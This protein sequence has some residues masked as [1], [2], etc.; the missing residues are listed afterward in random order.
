MDQWLEFAKGPLFAITFL[1]ML[2]GLTR[3][4]VVQV[5]LLAT[6][7]RTLRRVA[8]RR[9]L[10]DSLSWVLPFQHLTRGT[11]ILTFTSILFHAGAILVPLFLAD[12]VVLWES[13]LGISLPRLSA[14]AADTLTL[15]TIALVLVLLS[16]RV[17]T[18]RSR[19]LSKTGDY[20]ILAVVLLPFVT[21][22]LAAHPGI[23]PLPWQTMML[24]HV[25]SAEALFLTIPFTK[26]AHIVLFPFDRLSQVHWQLRAGAGEKVA[27]ALYGEEAKV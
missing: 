17:L 21:G 19:D 10:G 22:Y 12:H 2:L 4:V 7:G 24:F 11:L 15:L 8:W 23:N 6:K 1:I 25:L 3:H 13:L 20:I 14:N 9:V 16:Y 27:I 18:T 26:L 5:Q